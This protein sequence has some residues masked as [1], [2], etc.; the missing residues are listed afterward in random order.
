MGPHFSEEKL[1]Q[2]GKAYEKATEWYKK[3]PM[4]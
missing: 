4:L 1:F 3:K 2:I